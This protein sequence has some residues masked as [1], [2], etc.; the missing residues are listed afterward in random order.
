MFLVNYMYLCFPIFLLGQSENGDCSRWAGAP[1]KENI[2][3]LPSGS[4]MSKKKSSFCAKKTNKQTKKADWTMRNT[5]YNR[6]IQPLFLTGTK[7]DAPDLLPASQHHRARAEVLVLPSGSSG[8][9]PRP[10]VGPIWIKTR[11]KPIQCFWSP[12]RTPGRIQSL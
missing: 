2:L 8:L 12:L 1:V 3:G 10:P 7:G 11:T 4:S 6:H 5:K 9:Q